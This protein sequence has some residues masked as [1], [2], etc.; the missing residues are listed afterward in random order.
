MA[1]MSRKENGPGAGVTGRNGENPN[2][3]DP[4]KPKPKPRTPTKPST[5]QPRTPPAPPTGSRPSNPFTPPTRGGGTT[6]AAP[7]MPPTRTPATPVAKPS[8]GGIMPGGDRNGYLSKFTGPAMQQGMRSMPMTPPPVTTAPG[9]QTPKAGLN[10][11]TSD[12]R[13]MRSGLAGATGGARNTKQPYGMT[14]RL[15]RR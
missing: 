6:A 10:Q 4:K 11:L 13:K 1:R 3:G 5:P 9:L 14:N 15:P 8:V 7:P 2:F 12:V